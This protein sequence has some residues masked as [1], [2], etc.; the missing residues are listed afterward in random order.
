MYPTVGLQTPGEVVDANFGQKP[1]VYDIEEVMK[2][3]KHCMIVFFAVIE[4]SKSLPF[5]TLK[6]LVRQTWLDL[7]ITQIIVLIEKTDKTIIWKIIDVV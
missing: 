6:S 3:C 4:E 5:S 7:Q 2:V 1:F